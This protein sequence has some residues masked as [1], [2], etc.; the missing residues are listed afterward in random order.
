MRVPRTVRALV[1]IAVAVALIVAGGLLAQREAPPADVAAEVVQPI[2]TSTLLC[3]EPGTGSD[4][5]TR[6]TAGVV[7]GLPGQ[8]SEGGR[9]VIETLPGRPQASRE[10]TAPGQQAQITGFGRR[11]PPV[12]G[13]AVGALA[14]GFVADQWS[15]DPGGRGRG[16][17]STACGP[18]AAEFWFV[19]GGSVAGRKTRIVLVNPDDSA[20]VVDVIVHGVN[21]PVDAPAGRGLV[22]QPRSREVVS[23]DAL[24]PG[25]PSTAIHVIARAG[26]I[27]ATVDDDHMNGLRSVG[28]DWLP[29]AAMPAT[30]VVVPGV[31]PGQGARV[32]TVVAPGDDDALVSIR[33][34]TADGPFA[35]A[36]RDSMRV[37]AG[38]VASMDLAPVIEGQAAAIEI[39]SNVP[40]TAG[41]RQFVGGARKPQRD[42]TFSAATEPFLGPA[43]VSGL[44]VRRATTV[45]LSVTAPVSDVAVDVTLL[46]YA[47]QGAVSSPTKPKRV[48]VRAQQ[49]GWIELDAPSGTDWYTAI[50]T[51]VRGSGPVLVAHRVR[52]A[53]AFGDLVTGY[54]WSP[55]RVQVRVPTASQDLS[56]T[57]R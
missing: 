38:A 22:V 4:T 5:G 20:A 3:P 57:V 34:L 44:P 43:A 27:G 45:H 53:S 10:L 55:L 25:E 50:V 47:G 15:R 48:V 21:G 39:T 29:P 33:V 26:R 37:P 36:E 42:T 14:P 17:A 52:E 18:A 23:L 8:Q 54:P 16:M 2:G 24:V 7:P 51:P 1:L 13:I 41:L 35:P 46:P 12:Q 6:V 31:L 28:T 11:L 32:L 19:G 9:A 56:L 30:D 49:V 40:V